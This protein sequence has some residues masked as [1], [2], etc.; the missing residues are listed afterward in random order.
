VT[1]KITHFCCILVNFWSMLRHAIL[2]VKSLS[3]QSAE[4]ECVC[5]LTACLRTIVFLLHTHL[6]SIFYSIIIFILN[7]SRLPWY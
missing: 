7:E 1:A 2:C 4:A 5:M 3:Y 6:L